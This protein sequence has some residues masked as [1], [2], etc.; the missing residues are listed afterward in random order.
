MVDEGE[1]NREKKK[2]VTSSLI[3]CESGGVSLFMY[4][5]SYTKVIRM[6]AWM[7]RFVN[8]CRKSKE[9][10]NTG[11]I[12]VEEIT[13]AEKIIVKYSMLKGRLSMQI[14]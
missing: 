6:V 1:V 5:S 7:K 14:I 9:H 2:G 12:S 4:F 13:F 11:N 10:R 3:T 8:N